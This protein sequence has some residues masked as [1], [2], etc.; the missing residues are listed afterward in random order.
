[1]SGAL[2]V[3]LAAVLGGI[4]GPAEALAFTPVGTTATYYHPS[5]HGAVMASG[6][7]YNRW[8]PT[9]AACNWFPL[10]TLL[11]VTRQGTDRYIYV[12]VQD[13]GSPR[14]TL[15]LSE[16]GF[17]QLGHLSEGRIPIWIEVVTAME[18]EPSGLADAPPDTP[19]LAAEDGAAEEALLTGSPSD[20]PETL[21]G[22][23]E[24]SL[25]FTRPLLLSRIPR[26]LAR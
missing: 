25:V 19:P 16:A 5:L 9:I 24:P 12:R 1:M 26:L 22:A 18:A 20:V 11:K 10:G 7:R 3:L 15:D 14:L 4:L 13:R 21:L 8:D 6:A 23:V 2:R 17:A